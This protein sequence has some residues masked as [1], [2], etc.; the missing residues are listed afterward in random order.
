VIDA[1]GTNVTADDDDPTR[2]LIMKAVATRRRS[3]G[4]RH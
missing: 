4:I 1:S 2:I 3:F